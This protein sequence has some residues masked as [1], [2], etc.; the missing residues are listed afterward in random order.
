MAEIN[1]T[2]SQIDELILRLIHKHNPDVV[3]DET[4]FLDLLKHSLSLNV[5]EKKRVVDAMPT[6]S[7]FQIN[8]LKKVF[9]EERDKFRELAKEYPEDI[10]KLVKKQQ[11]EWSQLGDIYTAEWEKKETEGEDQKKIDDLKAGLW[12]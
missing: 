6:L 4:D 12:L 1:M 9:L 11:T 5:M 3:F 8:E 7:Q 2:E 10:K